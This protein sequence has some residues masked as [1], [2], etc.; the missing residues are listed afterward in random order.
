[1]Q[2]WSNSASLDMQSGEQITNLDDLQDIDELH[3]VEV[4]HHNCHHCP[5]AFASTYKL[6]HM[7]WAHCHSET[8]MDIKNDPATVH[9]LAQFTKRFAHHLPASARQPLRFEQT[10]TEQPLTKTVCAEKM[11]LP[12]SLGSFL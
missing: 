9:Q 2:G 4:T 11:G 5:W 6:P 12:L 1:M 3:V 8:G 7:C 10:N